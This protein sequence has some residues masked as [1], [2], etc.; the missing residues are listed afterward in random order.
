MAVQLCGERGLGRIRL[1]LERLLADGS[2][3]H[4]LRLAAEHSLGEL[5][6]LR[7]GDGTRRKKFHIRA[8]KQKENS[9]LFTRDCGCCVQV[10]VP[11]VWQKKDQDKWPPRKLPLRHLRRRHLRRRLPPRRRRLRRRRLPP[12]RRLLRRRRLPRRSPRRRHAARR[13]RLRRRLLPRRNKRLATRSVAWARGFEGPRALF[14]SER[15]FIHG[16]T[17]CRNSDGQRL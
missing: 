16:Q 11:T 8:C 7:T 3:P 12:R 9:L 2:T 15:E 1:V 4:P 5:V 10:D 14:L 6:S 13:R 17:S